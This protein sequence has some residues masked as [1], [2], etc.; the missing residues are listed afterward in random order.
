MRSRGCDRTLFTVK[1]VS[2][3]D[4]EIRYLLPSKNWSSGGGRGS[5]DSALEGSQD[6]ANWNH[7]GNAAYKAC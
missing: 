4:S 6:W 2:K 3:H 5:T 7:P 1:K